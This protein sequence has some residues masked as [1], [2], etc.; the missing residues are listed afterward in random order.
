MVD[1][2]K[3]SSAEQAG[4]ESGDVV[5]T[6]NGQKITSSADLPALIGLAQPG[7]TMLLGV[8]H[9]EKLQPIRVQL[10]DAKPV[11]L[12]SADQPTGKQIKGRLGLALRPLQSNEMRSSGIETGLLIEAVTGAAAKANKSLAVLVQ[13]GERKLYVPLRLS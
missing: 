3:G 7:D 6:V 11:A 8:W 1:V 12:K 13:R 4:L 9:L 2:I 5:L 10:G